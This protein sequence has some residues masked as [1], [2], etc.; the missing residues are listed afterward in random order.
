MEVYLATTAIYLS[1]KKVRVSVPRVRD[2]LNNKEVGLRTLELLQQPHDADEGVLR[3]ILLGLSC[4][5]YQSCAEAVPEAFGLSASSISRR[6]IKASSRK[7]K[8]LMERD[9]SGYDFA[10]VFILACCK[11][12]WQEPCLTQAGLLKTR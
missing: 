1:D 2:A 9:L 3:K 6:F 4:R 7:L 5:D 12:G 10:V 8:E 11:Q